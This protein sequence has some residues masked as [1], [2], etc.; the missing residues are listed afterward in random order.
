M[1]TAA[2]IESKIN[3]LPK[4]SIFTYADLIKEVEKKEATIKALNR[5]AAAEKIA[6]LSKGK[7]YV[8]ENT[9][10][11]KL[12]P[13]QSEVVKDLLEDDGKVVGYL[14]GYS[15]YNKLGLTTQIANTIQ[16]GKND[17]RPTF[18]RGRYT[19][20]FIKQKNIIT[21]NNIELL[22]IL[23]AIRYI[24]KIPDTNVG[25]SCKRLIAI[26]KK[27]PLA[28]RK[29]LVRL[30]LKYPPATRALVGAMLEQMG[31][32]EIASSLLKTLNPITVYKFN[33]LDK[34]LTK[35]SNW[36]IK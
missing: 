17:F 18:K 24:K 16:I 26:I 19:I 25:S 12:Q 3:K 10:F 2:Y 21:E 35:A 11:G 32:K 36:N 33:G 4:G 1:S 23:D 7:F 28:E 22:Q 6:K 34:V 15:I 31:S 27:L 13:N 5:M 29:L 8:P 14:T 9:V 30:S 20:S